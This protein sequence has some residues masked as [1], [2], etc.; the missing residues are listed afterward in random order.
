[1]IGELR[2]MVEQSTHC[3]TNEVKDDGRLCYEQQWNRLRTE[4]QMSCKMIGEL[5]FIVEQSIYCTTN[6]LKDDG[7]L[8]YEK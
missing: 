6:E 5:R 4:P 2:S 8:C 7:W 1:M 3:T